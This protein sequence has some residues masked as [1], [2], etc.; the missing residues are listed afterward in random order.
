MQQDL[1]LTVWILVTLFHTYVPAL[2][3]NVPFCNL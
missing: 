3:F 1:K 2:S